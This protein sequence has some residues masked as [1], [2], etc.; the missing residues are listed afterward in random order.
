[1]VNGK[2]KLLPCTVP[3]CPKKIRRSRLEKH[4]ASKHKGSKLNEDVPLDND[5]ILRDQARDHRGLPRDHA[6]D[7][8]EL[9]RDQRDH[10]RDHLNIQ[11]QLDIVTKVIE[12]ELI[13]TCSKC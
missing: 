8:E 13:S 3:G 12:I 9:P 7:H 4:I 5:L 6:S 1:M 2:Q 11:T 10:G